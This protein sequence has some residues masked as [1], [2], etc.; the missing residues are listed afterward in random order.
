[1]VPA[2]N[3]SAPHTNVPAVTGVED[4]V[5]VARFAVCVTRESALAD[6]RSVPSDAYRAPKF[7]LD[8]GLTPDTAWCQYSFVMFA[9]R[10]M[11]S[12]VR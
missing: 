1:M 12:F 5:R 2:L 9:E 10:E 6:T 4:R 7:W 3:R 11:C 8:V